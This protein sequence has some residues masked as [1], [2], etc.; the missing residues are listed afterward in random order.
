MSYAQTPPPEISPVLSTTLKKNLAIGGYGD[1]EYIQVLNADEF[2]IGELDIHRLVLLM[3]YQFN[4]KVKMVTEIEFEHV[5][6]VFVEQIFVDY[7]INQ[8][9]NWRSGLILIPMGIINERHESNTFNGAIRPFVDKYMV[10]TT[11][12]E[13]GTGFH[14]N[15]ID[16][17]LRY[18]AYIVNGFNGYNGSAKLNGSNGLRS[19]RQKGAESY[20]SS[21]NLSSKIEYYGIPNLNIGLAGYFGKTQTTALNGID[22]SNEALV[23]AADSTRVGLSMLGLDA[24]YLKKGFQ[25]KAQVIYTNIN[26]TIAYNTYT[27]SD[28][29]ANLFGYYIEAAYNVLQKNDEIKD[30]LL[31]FVRYETFNTHQKME[32]GFEINDSYNRSAITGGLTWKP[33]T[34]IA[35]KIDVQAL[36]NQSEESE[37]ELFFNAGIGFAF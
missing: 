15:I 12:R 6:E 34:L 8:A 14:G 4:P 1:I 29:A 7:K 19:G 16:A 10:P 25:M 20:I 28:L 33:N 17:S 26:N 27:G 3:A 11:W 35:Y 32:T 18:Q 37:T 21:P 30:E 2:S 36:N 13:I 5:S 31:P 9:L 22:K 24:R 23:A